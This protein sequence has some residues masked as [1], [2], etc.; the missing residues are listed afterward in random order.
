MKIL[1]NIIAL[2][3]FGLL[4]ARLGLDAWGLEMLSSSFSNS[5]E[6]RVREPA[7]IDPAFNYRPRYPPVMRVHV[8]LSVD[9]ASLDELKQRMTKMSWKVTEPEFQ[10]NDDDWLLYGNENGFNQM[11]HDADLFNETVF[12]TD[13]IIISA[14]KVK[15]LLY[16]AGL[17]D[18]NKSPQRRLINP[19]FKVSLFSETIAKEFE[20]IS[21]VE[22]NLH[23]VFKW[24]ENLG[25]LNELASLAVFKFDTEDFVYVDAFQ[26]DCFFEI[27]GESSMQLKPIQLTQILKQYLKPED[28]LVHF[29]STSKLIPMSPFSARMISN[30]RNIISLTVLDPG[31]L[32][33]AEQENSR[34]YILRLNPSVSDRDEPSRLLST[35]TK[36]TFLTKIVKR[37]IQSYSCY[38][39]DVIL[40]INITEITSLV[41]AKLRKFSLS[42]D[43][44]QVVPLPQYT[45]A[46]G[47][48]VVLN[49]V[50]GKG[51]YVYIT[52]GY[53]KPIEYYFSYEIKPK[54]STFKNN[55]EDPGN[56]VVNYERFAQGKTPNKKNY[57]SGIAE[58][59]IGEGYRYVLSYSSEERS[60]VAFDLIKGNMILYFDSPFPLY[61]VKKLMFTEEEG[62]YFIYLVCA[63]EGVMRYNMSAPLAVLQR[64]LVGHEKTNYFR[65][66]KSRIAIAS[67]DVRNIAYEEFKFFAE[68]FL[69]F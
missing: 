61:N 60:I 3:L 8:P 14:V 48:T 31:Y 17:E 29:E 40:F 59:H 4:S 66:A 13:S 26:V 53:G 5:I 42:L 45:V 50:G 28:I 15:D 49:K 1:V 44:M 63:F 62:R 55:L 38:L 56:L 27:G 23:R 11:F 30:G 18:I 22:V 10:E 46:T 43:I 9:K 19:I 64:D 52:T 24:F 68:K 12:Y 67:P 51:F 65:T 37:N 58:Y 69:I 36:A 20:Y 57:Y 6:R 41:I 47:M 21:K 39:D 32:I 35:N 7:E 33:W 34:I 54:N 2:N 25:L 16:R